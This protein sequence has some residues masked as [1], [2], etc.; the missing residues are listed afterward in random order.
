VVE[1]T[2]LALRAVRNGIG[3]P[4]TRD[5][6]R[7]ALGRAGQRNVLLRQAYAHLSDRAP[8]EARRS[9]GRVR[10]LGLPLGARGMALGILALMPAPVL[11]GLGRVK[12]LARRWL[13]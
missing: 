1:L 5:R 9:L 10:E 7:A 6:L 11:G 4:G 13:P 8:R 3:G 2:E 12:A